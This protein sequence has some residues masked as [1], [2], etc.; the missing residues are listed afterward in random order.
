MNVAFLGMGRMGRLM[1]S[2]I[3]DAGHDLTIW[4]RTPGK[5]G[6]L[7]SR[8]AREATTVAEA[9]T[10]ADAIVLMLFGGD[11]VHEVLGQIGDAA[12]DGTLVIDSTSNGPEAAR[13]LGGEANSLGL[14]YVDAPVAG[15]LPPAKDGV[16]TIFVGGSDEDFQ[17]ARPLLELWGDPEKVRHLGPVGAGNA[18]KAV[19]NQCLGLAMAGVGEALQLA[20]D[21]SL[22][23]TVVLDA[24]EAGPFGW[25]IKQ[26][27]KMLDSGDF[28]ATTFS[29]DLMAKDLTV[30]L[31]NAAGKMP[32][33]EAAL[34]RAKA[35]VDAGHGDEDYASMAG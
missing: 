33:T 9:V 22:D 29:L 1:A 19:V 25:S 13:R 16:L 20:S 15:S 14:R 32:L 26:K 2:H 27:R 6:E 31:D 11:S 3:I 24:L 30:A 18:L 23:T 12:T 21:L 4:N 35:A 28:S 17:D 34:G 10:G 5:A 8:G 7:T